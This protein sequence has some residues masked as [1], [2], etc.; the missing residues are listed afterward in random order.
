M[1]TPRPSNASGSE[2]CVEYLDVED[3]LDVAR[4]LLDDP[5]P[6]P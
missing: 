1:C 4:L 3:V 6:I 5:R 2:V